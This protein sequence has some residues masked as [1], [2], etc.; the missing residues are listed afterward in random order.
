M[1]VPVVQAK[2]SKFNAAPIEFTVSNEAC[3]HSSDIDYYLQKAVAQ[4]LRAANPRNPRELAS[5]FA[6]V[7]FRS[8]R[9]LTVTGVGVNY[10]STSVFFREPVRK[11]RWL[12]Q[13]QGV[14]VAANNFV[15]IASQE[16]VEV[17]LLRAVPRQHQWHRFDVVI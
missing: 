9:G 13:L 10:E 4:R 3:F 2:R 1:M 11:V 7:S 15:P 14:Y 8:W 6:P 17:Q 5:F 16:A 12:L